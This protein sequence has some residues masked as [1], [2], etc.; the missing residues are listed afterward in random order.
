ML[1]KPDS[2]MSSIHTAI[3]TSTTNVVSNRD[4]ASSNHRPKHTGTL[5]HTHLQVDRPYTALNSETYIAVRQQELWT[6]K[7]ITY[8]FYCVEFFVVKHI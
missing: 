4:S 2:T 8:E 7:R 1:K 3:Q 5:L 6:C